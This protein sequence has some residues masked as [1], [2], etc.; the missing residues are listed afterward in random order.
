MKYLRSGR[1]SRLHI[2]SFFLSEKPTNNEHTL[3]LKSLQDYTILSEPLNKH[4]GLAHRMLD[5]SSNLKELADTT[6][7]ISSSNS[8]SSSSKATAT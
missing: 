8:I 5:G 4:Q 2:L 1:K 3:L 7:N 6:N